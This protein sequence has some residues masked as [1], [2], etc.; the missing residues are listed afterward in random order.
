M[1]YDDE[2]ELLKGII[3][4]VRGKPECLKRL[5]T[6]TIT[7]L[8]Y[9]FMGKVANDPIIEGFEVIEKLVI[10]PERTTTYLK[11]I[12][13][14]EKSGWIRLIDTPGRSFTDEPPFSYLQTC[15]ELGDTFHKEI[16]DSQNVS[17][18]FT[19][20][21]TCLDALFTYL[22]AIINDDSELYRVT[23]SE[24][25]LSSVEPHGWF[26][27][28]TQRVQ[29]STCKLPAAEAQKKY[30][31]S[32]YQYLALVGLLG[33]RDGD[34]SFDFSDTSEVTSLFAQGRVCRQRMKEHLFGQKNPLIRHRLLEG[35]RGE[36][37]ETV[38]L[39]QLGAR[40][41][42]GKSQCKNSDDLKQRVKKNTLFDLEE[43][44]VKKE[45]V[46]LPA[47]VTEAIQSLIFSESRQGRKVREGWHLSLPAAW[48]SPTGSTVLLYGP[49]G[50]GK[51]LTAQYLASEL[52]LP[53][54]KI[55]AS[56]V[57]SCWVGESEQNVRRIFDDYSM[58]QKELG[59]SPVLLL[60]EADQL[61]WDSSS[62]E[63][64][65]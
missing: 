40:V 1:T 32:I 50:T 20:N 28:I 12:G 44:K 39:S 2:V 13:E 22:Q 4:S 61:A 29:A 33:M 38:Q 25:D 9:I 6:S 51:T 60:N 5:S 52:K 62:C 37:G 65:K 7:T 58:L 3:S 49:P 59:K 14:L 16:G 42:L 35:T 10:D 47:Q 48:G 15:I 53:L 31:L 11:S 24:A 27:R 64:M 54:L 26:R 63:L 43:P 21:D 19:S 56:R 45:S 17:R 30:S 18:S 46:Q 41:L 23:N 34:V 55:D 36:F 57:L 8:A